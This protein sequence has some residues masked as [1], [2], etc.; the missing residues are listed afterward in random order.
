MRIKIIA[1][2]LLFYMLSMYCTVYVSASFYTKPSKDMAL[3]KVTSGLATY[4][5]TLLRG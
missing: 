4:T 5:T 1:G 3:Y 2:L